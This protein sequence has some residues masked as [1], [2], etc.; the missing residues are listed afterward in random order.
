ML[1][2]WVVEIDSHTD[3]STSSDGVLVIRNAMIIAEATYQLFAGT[4]H[5]ITTIPGHLV[6]DA[7]Y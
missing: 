4:L 1:L 6:Q 2:G 5:Q 7:F 3:A